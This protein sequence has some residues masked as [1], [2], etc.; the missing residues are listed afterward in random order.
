MGLVEDYLEKTKFYKSKYGVKTIV[1]MQVG[2]FYE[3]YA[4]SDEKGKYIGSEIE[5][6]SRICELLIADKK[7]CVGKN[8]V[9]MAGVRDYVLDKYLAKLQKAGYTIPV[10]DQDTNTPNTTRSLR[11]IYSAGTSFDNDNTVITN[12]TMCIWIFAIKK[13]III[14]ISNINILTGKTNVFEYETENLNSPIT[15]DE[16]ERAVSVYS[17]TELIIITNTDESKVNNLISYSNINSKQK[18]IYY[19]NDDELD[20][21]INTKIENCEKQIYQCELLNKFFEFKN[22][23]EI[24]SNFSNYPILLQSFCFLLDFIN[25]HNP[26]LINKISQPIFD[27]YTNRVILANH[28][29][30]QLNIIDD[31]NSKGPFSSVLSFLNKCKTNMGKRKFTYC[32]LNPSQDVDYLKK[33]YDITEYLISNFET[34]HEIKDKISNITDIEKLSRK[35]F[36]KQIAPSNIVTLYKNIITSKEIING[37]KS[38]D[39]LNEYLSNNISFNYLT[40]EKDCDVIEEEIRRVINIEKAQNMNTMTFDDN[41]INRNINSVI[42]EKERKYYE[43]YDKLNCIK[44]FLD[45]L[46]K[47]TEKK[48]KTTDYIKIHITSSEV[49]LTT[50]KKRSEVLKIELNKN[51]IKDTEILSYKSSYD[52]EDKELMFNTK[53]ITYD[54]ST[55]TNVSIY[56]DILR[57]IYSDN[58]NSKLEL[59]DIVFN[60]YIEFVIKL[61]CFNKE[62][63]NISEYIATIDVLYN[64]AKF[65]K[66]YNYCKPTIDPTKNKSFFSATKVRHCLIEHIQTDELYV[67]NDLSL[68]DETTGVLLY[69]TNAVGKTSFIRALGI[70]IIMAQAG[71]YVP[72]ESLNFSPYKNIFSRIIGNDNLFKGLSTFAVEMHELRNILKYSDNNSLI[73]GDELCSGT[74]MQSAIS[75][76][77][78]GIQHLYNVESSF[79]FA[80]HLHEITNYEE[81]INMSKLALKHLTVQYDNEADKLVFDRIIKDGPGDNTY[82]LEFCKSMNMPNDFLDKAYALRNKYSCEK[83]VLLN[84]QSHF[85]SKKI[86]GMCEICKLNKSCEVHHLQYQNLANSDGYINKEFH[87]NHPANLCNVCLD[88]HRKIHSENLQINRRKTSDGFEFFTI[89]TI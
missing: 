73:L 12:N 17:P 82:G 52:G 19:I 53:N 51:N 80:T 63:N 55:Q 49:V 6:F 23:E 20:S 3:V 84:E 50:T 42:D 76:F 83:S 89:K 44:N 65:S 69:G 57:E 41:F 85:N 39:S 78:T 79:I 24:L 28:T 27:N 7:A 81:I 72:C 74:E 58:K 2:A 26:H 61:Q 70:T 36:L 10:Y 56:N 48:S 18:H 77:V 88:C 14:G 32:L 1:M 35:I 45:S 43:S 68:G 87:K 11:C 21:E 29:L 31:E 40:I 34:I 38:L 33:E 59:K 46:L 64:K 67:T 60:V 66:K 5:E 37:L 22:K 54:K 30:K 15:Y 9:Y 4:L 75:I 25:D 16:L 8:K 62:I 71:M 13:K 86:K 47:N